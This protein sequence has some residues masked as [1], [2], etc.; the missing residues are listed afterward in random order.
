MLADAAFHV[1]A[2]AAII[3]ASGLALDDI[4]PTA[5]MDL[6]KQKGPIKGDWA[7]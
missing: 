7:F 3:P 6:S 2:V 4:N 1:V 5:H